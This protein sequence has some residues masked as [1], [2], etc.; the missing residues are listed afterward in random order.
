MTEAKTRF[1]YVSRPEVSRKVRSLQAYS[2]PKALSGGCPFLHC[3]LHDDVA[4]EVESI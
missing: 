1:H 3:F 4:A 2:L